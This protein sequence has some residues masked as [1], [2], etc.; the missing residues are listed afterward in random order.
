MAWWRVFDRLPIY[1]ELADLVEDY[2]RVGNV[3]WGD[4]QLNELGY[5]L[6]THRTWITD[7]VRSRLIE[8]SRGGGLGNL[9]WQVDGNTDAADLYIVPSPH[10]VEFFIEGF[11]GD[12][13][14][15]ELPALRFELYLGHVFGLGGVKHGV[16]GFHGFSSAGIATHFEVATR[17]PTPT[18]TPYGWP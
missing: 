3:H 4:T 13:E 9:E 18:P 15:D 10:F 17:W 12:D 8:M 7:S 16:L 2:L 6:E 14:L 11:P 5:E 1:V